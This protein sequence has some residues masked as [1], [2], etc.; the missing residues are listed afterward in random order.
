MVGLAQLKVGIKFR[1]EQ[2]DN[3]NLN[4]SYA[5]TSPIMLSQL[6]G[7]FTDPSFYSELAPGYH[8]GP[9]P[10]HGATF[11]FTLADSPSTPA[12]SDAHER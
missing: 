11:Y 2:R 1:D 10:N 4:R 7:G 3:V 6:A 8:M 5:A 9:Q 12:P